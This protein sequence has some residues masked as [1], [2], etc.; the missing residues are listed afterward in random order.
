[1]GIASYLNANY[2]FEPSTYA[3]V[4]PGTSSNPLTNPKSIQAAEYGKGNF[5]V[6]HSDNSWAEGKHLSMRRNF[7][8]FTCILY[9]NDDWQ[10]QDGGALRIYRDST[11]LASAKEAHKSCEYSDIVPK[12]GRLVIFDSK[13]VHSVE[14]VLVD[15][16]RRALT[17][18]IARPSD[19]GIQ[20][21]EI[22]VPP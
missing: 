4:L 6:A 3:P 10:E 2:D 1:M 8:S 12:N 20:G 11:H 22:D 13:L 17:I 16:C 21:E 14:K 15:K 18:W 5:Y 9:C 19:G 7:R